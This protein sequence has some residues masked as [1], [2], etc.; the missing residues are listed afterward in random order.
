MHGIDQVHAFSQDGHED[1]LHHHGS[2][3]IQIHVADFA[4]VS[5]EMDFHR[6]EESW[7]VKVATVPLKSTKCW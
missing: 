3:I 5:H 2:Q 4:G 7:L 1:S 6:P